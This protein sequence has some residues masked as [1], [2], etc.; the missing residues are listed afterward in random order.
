MLTRDIPQYL[1]LFDSASDAVLLLPPSSL[2]SALHANPL[3]VLTLIHFCTTALFSLLSNPS[4]PQGDLA[5]EALNAVRV[6]S[7]VVPLILAPRQAGALDEVEEELFWRRDKAPVR[8]EVGE[9]SPTGNE[10]AKAGDAEGQF[11]LE[12][13]DDEDAATDPLASASASSSAAQPT[14]EQQPAFEEIPPLAERL[15]SALVDLLFVPGFTL[16][17]SSRSSTDSSIVTYSIWCVRSRRLRLGPFL[18][19][20]D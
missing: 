4:F 18:V 11:V 7:R 15:L 16:P 17:E 1:T 14:A 12:D 8:K 6:L 3:N 20:W 5:N 9:E 10:Q 13:E 19:I 2:L